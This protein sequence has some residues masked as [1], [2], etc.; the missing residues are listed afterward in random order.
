M[1][2]Q[3]IFDSTWPGAITLFNGRSK[4]KTRRDGSF[5]RDGPEGPDV[6]LGPVEDS[7]GLG[8]FVG[9]LILEDYAL[10]ADS[11]HPPLQM[12]KDAR[13]RPRAGDEVGETHAGAEL[14][15]GSEEFLLGVDVQNLVGLSR[16]CVHRMVQ[17]EPEQAPPCVVTSDDLP[18]T[19]VRGDSGPVPPRTR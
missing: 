3:R 10:R 19:R 6:E 9:R 5:A 13:E 11:R 12:G 17:E 16:V 2:R 4:R 7:L 1:R 8:N 14:G 18:L 15:P